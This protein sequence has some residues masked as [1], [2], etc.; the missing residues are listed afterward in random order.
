MTVTPSFV[1]YPACA[2]KDATGVTR[3]VAKYRLSQLKEELRSSDW[4]RLIRVSRELCIYAVSVWLLDTVGFGACCIVLI[5]RFATPPVLQL[6]VTTRRPE[7]SLG[8]WL[9]L[10]STQY[11]NSIRPP[12]DPF[13]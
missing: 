3:R 9:M 13:H 2:R 6:I 1:G 7:K 8:I 4:F 5:S 12:F 10:C 11:A